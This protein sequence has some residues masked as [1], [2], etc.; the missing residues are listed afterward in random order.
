MTQ[1]WVIGPEHAALKAFV[2]PDSTRYAMNKVQIRDG[3]ARATD[4]RVA[5]AVPLRQVTDPGE[6]RGTQAPFDGTVLVN[7]ATLEKAL[8]VSGKNG[9]SEALLSQSPRGPILSTDDKDLGT[10]TLSIPQCDD[11]F[12]EVAKVIPERQDVGVFV[13]SIAA[14]L[15]ESIAAYVARHGCVTAKH[16]IRFQ[17]GLDENGKHDGMGVRFDFDLESGVP[18]SGAFMPMSNTH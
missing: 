7:P 8:K 15:L 14:S 10:I 5:V 12:P 9:A 1:F 4:G 17:F 3:M 6:H 13:V 11:K 2:D 16:A 18:A